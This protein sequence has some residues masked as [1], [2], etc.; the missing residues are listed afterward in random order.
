MTYIKIMFI[1]L[2]LSYSCS[3]LRGIG[4]LDSYHDKPT[5]ELEK[6]RKKV[7]HLSNGKLGDDTR[8]GF[9]DRIDS[10]VLGR[11]ILTLKKFDFEIDIVKEFWYDLG[12][13]RRIL[14]IAHELM[15]C[16]CDVFHT[17]GK[18]KD[19]CPRSFMNPYL[20]DEHCSIVHFDRYVDEMRR[21]CEGK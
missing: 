3:N 2:G 1:I 16:Q 21:G 4:R 6:Y 13:S 8:I 15:H 10:S 17:K 19:G 11:C 7:M 5:P 20:P 12:Q 18:L 9:I 14:L